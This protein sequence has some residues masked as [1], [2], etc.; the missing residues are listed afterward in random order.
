MYFWSPLKLSVVDDIG[1]R[2]M[3]VINI[4]LNCTKP[5]TVLMRKGKKMEGMENAHPPSHHLMVG[6]CAQTKEGGIDPRVMM[7]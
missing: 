6:G 2:I 7:D 4:C 5:Y 3:I 1:W